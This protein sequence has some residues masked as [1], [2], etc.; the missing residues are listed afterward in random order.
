MKHKQ[1]LPVAQ[2]ALTD[3]DWPLHPQQR[4][5]EL[6]LHKRGSSTYW[7]PEWGSLSPDMYAAW[8]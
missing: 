5:A 3:T 4:L 2:E 7:L 6:G 8:V 1:T